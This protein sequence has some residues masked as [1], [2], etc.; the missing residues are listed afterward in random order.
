MTSTNLAF[1]LVAAIFLI[2]WFGLFMGLNREEVDHNR[3]WPERGCI[4]ERQEIDPFYAFR[5]RCSSCSTAPSGTQSCDAA[6]DAQSHTDPDRCDAGELNYCAHEEQCHT[7]YKCCSECC[8]TCTDSKGNS[9]TCNCS[10]CHSTPRL[11]CTLT[12]YVHYE[13]KIW[14]YYVLPNEDHQPFM[15]THSHKDNEESAQEEMYSRPY[16]TS[17]PC[18]SDPDDPES[19]LFSIEYTDG[20]WAAS[21]IFAVLLL[22]TL[23]TWLTCA[24]IER[25]LSASQ[26]LVYGAGSIL[27]LFVG[28]M[29]CFISLDSNL[30]PDSRT[31][32]VIT[33][34]TFV[35]VWILMAI[36]TTGLPS[37]GCHFKFPQF[38]Q[39]T[40]MSYV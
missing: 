40:K 39:S 32:L 22:L 14:G 7:G 16:N 17:I 31:T 35:M 29:L 34:V 27:L 1:A 26:A 13:L 38:P 28:C 12:P 24:L 30:P 4:I 8:S 25:R 23:A 3:N 9:Y 15:Y 10:C 20:F 33:G 36:A 2:I 5:D 19:V 21:G 6:Q 18:W 11:E 37:S